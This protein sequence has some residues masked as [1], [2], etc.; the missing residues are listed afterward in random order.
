MGGRE[1]SGLPACRDQ[2]C[3]AHAPDRPVATV[4]RAGFKSAFGLKLSTYG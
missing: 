1:F 4:L 2:L 3:P